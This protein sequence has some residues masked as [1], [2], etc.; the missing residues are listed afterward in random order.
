VYPSRGQKLEVMS[1]AN[2]GAPPP[3][4]LKACKG[5]L[6]ALECR[7]EGPRL[8]ES[9]GPLIILQAPQPM[10]ARKVEMLLDAEE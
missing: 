6:R 7:R 8:N 5:Y 2:G 3:P 9:A 4:C 1:V 10:T